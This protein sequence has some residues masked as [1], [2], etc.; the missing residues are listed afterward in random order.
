[1]SLEATKKQKVVTGIGGFILDHQGRVWISSSTALAHSHSP[2][3][4]ETIAIWDGLR[5]AKRFG[6]ANFTLESD[7]KV[8]I[9]QL[10]SRS[11]LLS[12]L[13]HVHK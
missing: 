12:T 4:V 10:L 5:L 3:H 13:G 2:E 6:Y 7:C 1:M 8:A 9:D 11:D